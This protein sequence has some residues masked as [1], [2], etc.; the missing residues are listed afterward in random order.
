MASKQMLCAG[1]P[2]VIKGKQYLK[3][4]KCNKSYDLLCAGVSE[5][6]FLSFYG[7]GN[8]RNKATWICPECVNKKP[9]T[10]TTNTPVRRDQLHGGL[11]E[12]EFD[13]SPCDN[14]T[15]RSTSLRKACSD[16]DFADLSTMIRSEIRAAIRAEMT[17]INEKLHELQNSVQYISNQYDELIK[18]TNTIRHDFKIV[19]SE[20]DELR[21]TVSIM[22]DRV[23]TLEQH[24][25]NSNIE[26]QG[27]P[28]HKNENI[29][30]IINKVAEV[31]SLKLD[32]SDILL[33]TRVAHKNRDNKNPRAIVV[34]LRSSRC[35]DEF[36]SAVTR[37]NKTHPNEKLGSSLLGFGGPTTPIYV[38]EHLSPTNKSLHAAAR[39]KAKQLSYKFVW[40][41]NG[42]IYLRKNESA[43]F[44]HVKSQ[45]IL[46][47]LN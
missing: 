8:E 43:P 37:Y 18:T 21:A 13:D 7:A 26:I 20:C 44:I 2:N 30:S 25:R 15:Y 47:S 39:A 1:C 23:N 28:E 42:R 9:K 46:D 24:L 4:S 45:R 11:P 3:C 10:D 17:L 33:C 5:K 32:D 31:V 41:R 14:I 38:S 35:R 40:V 34:Q 22:T 16:T 36:Y 12:C 27:V 6:R 29:I 19:Q